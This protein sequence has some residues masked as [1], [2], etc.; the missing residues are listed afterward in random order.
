MLIWS[1]FWLEVCGNEG[2]FGETLLERKLWGVK[3]GIAL[4]GGFWTNQNRL[5][6]PVM[7]PCKPN[8]PHWNL[9]C[10]GNPILVSQPKRDVTRREAGEN[11][12]KLPLPGVNNHTHNTH[13]LHRLLVSVP[14]PTWLGLWVQKAGQR[15]VKQKAP[16][17]WT[18]TQ[19]PNSAVEQLKRIFP[20]SHINPSGAG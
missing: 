6:S 5:A 13:P 16:A 11:T 20:M 12:A 10:W 19:F 2:T 9:G 3:S 8:K 1:F 7:L 14:F 17:S 18:S 4:N 15:H